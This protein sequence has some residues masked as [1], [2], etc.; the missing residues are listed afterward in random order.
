MLTEIAELDAGTLL[1]IDKAC[2]GARGEH[3]AAVTNRADA[4]RAMHAEPDV[5]V[6]RELRFTRVDAYPDAYVGAFG[7]GFA[8]V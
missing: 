3:L 8:V 6:I 2:G 1:L 7:P 4:S 5:A